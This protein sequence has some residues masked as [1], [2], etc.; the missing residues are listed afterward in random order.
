LANVG[1]LLWQ[2]RLLHCVF[3]RLKQHDIKSRVLET[4]LL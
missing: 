4:N 1:D 3:S 2:I